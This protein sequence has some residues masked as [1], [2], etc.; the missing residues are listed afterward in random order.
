MSPPYGHGFL[1]Q[2]DDE[3]SGLRQSLSERSRE[4]ETK[5]KATQEDSHRIT[6]QVRLRQLI[7]LGVRLLMLCI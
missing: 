1:L 4:F 6:S 2:K 3:I 5:V 7:C